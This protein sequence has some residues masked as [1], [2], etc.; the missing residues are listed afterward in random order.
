MSCCA[1][2]AVAVAPK[3][4]SDCG[5]AKKCTTENLVPGVAPEKPHVKGAQTGVRAENSA[6]KCTPNCT[7]NPCTCK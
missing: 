5:D 6:C 3:C 7:C 1:D 2:Q 4:D